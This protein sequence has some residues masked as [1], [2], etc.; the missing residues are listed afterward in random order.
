MT[1][2]EPWAE[3]CTT[4][5]VLEIYQQTMARFAQPVVQPKPGCAEGVLGNAWSGELYQESRDLRPGLFFAAA[6]LVYLAKG[7][8]FSDGNKRVA[9]LTLLD[10]LSALGLDLEATEDDAADFVLEIAASPKPRVDD[11]LRWLAARVVASD[12]ALR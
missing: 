1:A 10:A 3:I 11:V 7:H 2:H 4:D 8:C 9:W 12:P 6:V 5:R